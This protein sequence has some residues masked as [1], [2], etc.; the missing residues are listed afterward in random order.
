MSGQISYWKPFRQG[1][2]LVSLQ[3]V[4]PFSFQCPTPDGYSREVRVIYSPHVFTR[5][6][7]VED[8]QSMVC[9]DQRI[10]CPDRYN[11]SLLLRQ[12]ICNLPNVQVHQTWEQRNY[13]FLAVAPATGEG[14]LHIFFELEKGGT[15][16]NKRLELRVESAY[17]TD[18]YAP[19]ARP[20]SIRFQMLVQNVFLGR[21]VRFAPR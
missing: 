10:F 19:P 5:S 12:E 14:L 9:F 3:H 15:K 18:T 11:D 13:V 21:P 16:K 8:D 4:E 1:G 6:I 17:R 2:Q 20:N 7:E